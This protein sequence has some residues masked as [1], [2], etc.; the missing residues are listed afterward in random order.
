M[1]ATDE[2]EAQGR[3]CFF[4]QRDEVKDLGGDEGG[5]GDPGVGEPLAKGGGVPFGREASEGATRDFCAM[6]EAV[7]ADMELGEG[8]APDVV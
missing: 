2:G 1:L 8:E 7:A 3:G 6:D 4:A 5:D